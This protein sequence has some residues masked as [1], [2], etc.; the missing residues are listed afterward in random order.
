MFFAA[1]S[2]ASFDD[3]AVHLPAVFLNSNRPAP[4]AFGETLGVLFPT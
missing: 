1:A 2:T 3:A 4:I